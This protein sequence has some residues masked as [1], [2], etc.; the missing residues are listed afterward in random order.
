MHFPD[1]P[2]KW[3]IGSYY[4]T[5]LKTLKVITFQVWTFDIIP[6]F[7]RLLDNIFFQKGIIFAILNDKAKI[8]D[9]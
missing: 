8:K 3:F 4:K 6:G 1:H 9:I 2:R 7:L 5:D